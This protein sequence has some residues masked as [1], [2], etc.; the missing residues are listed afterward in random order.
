M[1][2]PPSI[3]LRPGEYELKEGK[4]NLDREGNNSGKKDEMMN[5]HLLGC[6]KLYKRGKEDYI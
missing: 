4:K 3:T 6:S 2:Q 1:V 5:L